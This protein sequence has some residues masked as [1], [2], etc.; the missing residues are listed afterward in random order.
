VE[1]Q[2]Q[3]PAKHDEPGAHLTNGFAI[4]LAEDSNRLEVR[5]KPARQ[6]HHLNVAAI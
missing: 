3:S 4:A 6:P 2:I 1:R 5:N